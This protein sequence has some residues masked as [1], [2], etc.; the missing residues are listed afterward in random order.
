MNLSARMIFLINID[1][2]S[3][4]SGQSCKVSTIVNYDSRV[5]KWGIFNSGMTL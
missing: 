3:V 5:I 1:G 4:T 2:V